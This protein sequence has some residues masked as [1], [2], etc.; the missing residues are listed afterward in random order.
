MTRIEFYGNLNKYKDNENKNNDSELMHYGILGQK[1]GVRKWQN[2]D[3]TFNEAGKERYFGK[4]SKPKTT[5]EEK[6][7]SNKSNV[8]DYLKFRNKMLKQRTRSDLN[9]W[10]RDKMKDADKQLIK[11]AKRVDKQQM[12]MYKNQLKDFYDDP[13]ELVNDLDRMYRIGSNDKKIGG[14]FSKTPE[15]K[16]E[17]K[18]TKE[19]KKINDQLE[20]TFKYDQRHEDEV[21]DS[22]ILESE[23]AP[24]FTEL[25]QSNNQKLDKDYK[26]TEEIFKDFEKNQINNF[27]IAGITN[28][29]NDNGDKTM[30]DL[31]NE[32]KGYLFN[33][34]N[35]GFANAET[36]YTKYDKNIDPKEIENLY[37]NLHVKK[38][39]YDDNVKYLKDN[40][41]TLSKVK[42]EYLRRLVEEN[43]DS[44]INKS[45]KSDLAINSYWDLYN[46][47][48]DSKG[49][50]NNL[51]NKYNEAKNISSKLSKSCGN[52][53]LGWQLLNIALVNLELDKVNYKD[54][55]NSDWNNINKEINDLKK[56][57]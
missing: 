34:F 19:A 5:E 54:L 10:Y 1:W 50:D 27:A 8:K 30:T 28:F 20:E 37:Q 26:R 3:G 43:D 31:A 25:R 11:D 29:L 51:K 16:A 56:E 7:G 52:D 6:V 13:E 55:T 24:L 17:K 9:Q 23:F 40:N 4:S 47:A 33:D 49:Y 53:G 44:W 42:D 15:E 22:Y 12:K 38:D 39:L 2:Y 48:D 21:M 36:L 14:L 57:W 46:A 18:A 35:Q 32:V 41:K 45:T